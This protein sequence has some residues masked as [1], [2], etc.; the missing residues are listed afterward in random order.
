MENQA[1]TPTPRKIETSERLV[2]NLRDA[3]FAP[4]LIDGKEIPGQSFLQLDDTFP[5]GAGFTL[6]RMA[7]GS[8]SQPHEHTCH[9]QFFVIEGEVVDNDGFVYWPGDF[10]LL[11]QGAQHYPTTVTGATLAVF[12][13][14]IEKD[15]A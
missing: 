4:Y 8:S 3:R 11:K 15:I 9:E 5:A 14:E 1:M 12:V 13:R 2:R 10:V 6:Y 7:P